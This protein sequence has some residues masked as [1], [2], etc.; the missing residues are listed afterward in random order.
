MAP[1]GLR[2]LLPELNT[3]DAIAA[4]RAEGPP[5]QLVEEFIEFLSASTGAV[6]PPARLRRRQGAARALRG[7]R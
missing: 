2:H 4:L 6:T 5:P 1:S 7:R 3:S